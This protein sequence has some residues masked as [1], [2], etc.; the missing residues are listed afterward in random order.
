MIPVRPP[1]SVTVSKATPIITWSNPAD[2]T[3][4]TPLTSTQLDATA[5]VPGTF[6]YK[7]IS[8]TV[9]NVGKNQTLSVTFTPADTTDYTTASDSVSINVFSAPDFTLTGPTSGAFTAGQSVAI[10]WSDAN[11][12]GGSTISLAYDTANNWKNPKWIEVDKVIAA[13]GSG[14]YT[15][16]TAGVTAGV[17]YIAGYLYTPSSKTAVFSHLTTSFTVTAAVNTFE[18]TSPASGTFAAGQTIPVQWTNANVR[19]GSTISLA[20]DTTTNWGNPKWIEIGK[21]SAS[22]GSGSYSWNT[23]GLAA[24]TYYIAGYLYT[25][26]SKT[27]VFSH[28]A[29]SF[30]VLSPVF[31]LTTPA[32]G[33]FAP[34][35]TIPIQWTDANVSS[36]S[37]I[38]PA[39]DTTTNWR[40]PTWIEIGK[41]PATNGSGS[42][43]WNTAGITAG[44]YYIAGYMYTPSSKTAVFSHL[45]TS[46]S[47]TKSSSS[48]TVA[49]VLGPSREI[50]DQS[51][52][53]FLGRE[54]GA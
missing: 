53:E 37:T 17:Y 6:V 4:G 16:N 7:P 31:K 8:G 49:A 13:N 33:T 28:L 34:G 52:L 50:H 40:N 18:L 51:L 30:S 2:I 54:D 32:S 36:G 12:P 23:T 39:Y 42:Y 38:S 5:N 48:K 20:Y 41:V 24:G 21:V 11:V 22:N 19:S 10:Q 25:P 15:W 14:S 43:T 35:E 3:Y 9:L 1:L 45:T 44:A 26:S 27:A 46:F 29:T 47:V